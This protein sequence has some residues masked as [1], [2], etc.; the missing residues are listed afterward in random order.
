MEGWAASW[1]MGLE[2]LCLPRPLNSFPW[3]LLALG[4]TCPGLRGA[5]DAADHFLP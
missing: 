1:Q 4:R 5:L 3:N 2:A